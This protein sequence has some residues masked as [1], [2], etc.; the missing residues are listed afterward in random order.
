MAIRFLYPSVGM[1]TTPLCLL[2]LA[3][4]RSAPTAR[5]HSRL[6]TGS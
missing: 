5:P 4:S 1:T 3:V 6:E 2:L